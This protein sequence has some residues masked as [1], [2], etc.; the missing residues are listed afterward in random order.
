MKEVVAVETLKSGIP[1]VRGMTPTQISSTVSLAKGEG[2]YIKNPSQ[3]SGDEDAKAIFNVYSAIQ[4]KKCRFDFDDILVFYYELLKRDPEFLKQQ[5]SLFDHIMVDEYQDTNT[6]QENILSKLCTPESGIS[7]TCVGDDDQ[8]IYG[9]RGGRAEL[10]VSFQDRWVDTKIIKM[11]DNFRSAP[12]ILDAANTLI[13]N[14][15]VRTNKQ[16]EPGS[17]CVGETVL[18]TEPSPTAI[19]ANIAQTAYELHTD[20]EAPLQSMAVL[21]RTHAESGLIE[22]ALTDLNL[23]YVCLSQKE[24]FFGITEVKAVVSYL[25]LA[26]DPNNLA[27]LRFVWNKPNRFLK[28]TYFS[29]ARSNLDDPDVFELLDQA[30]RNASGNPRASRE[31]NQMSSVI[32]TTE[33]YIEQGS[34]AFEVIDYLLGALK[35]PAWLKEKAKQG[36]RSYEDLMACVEQLQADCEHRGSVAQYLVHVDRVI[37]NQKKK[38]TGQAIRL[39]TIHRSKGLEYPIVFLPGF[40]REFF[41]HPKSLSLEE[42]RRLAYVAITRA[43]RKLFIYTTETSPSKFCSELGLVSQKV[44]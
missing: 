17:D 30:A 37:A 41:P 38:D 19:A 4:L 21:Y 31:I 39:M 24:G 40:I 18:V 13:R 8:A 11:E 25:R 5:Q 32:R 34:D 27:A 44:E 22:S 10:I 16:L 7:L 1:A 29:D 2:A 12:P 35:Y 15:K 9:F 42:E 33:D 23:P 26:I 3:F 28:T 14:N 6:V 36:G 20:V 43:K